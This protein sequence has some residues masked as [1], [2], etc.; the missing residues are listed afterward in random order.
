ML[1][2]QALQATEGSRAI[3]LCLEIEDP[4]L[5]EEC[6]SGSVRLHPGQA[7]ACEGIEDPRWAGECWFSVAESQAPD[8]WAALDS[9]AKAGPYLQE[10]LYHLWTTELSQLLEQAPSIEE[11]MAPGIEIVEFWSGAEHLVMDPRTQLWNDFWFFAI[12]H[13][14]PADST[15]C[16]ELNPSIQLRCTDGLKAGVQRTLVDVLEDPSTPDGEADRACRSGSFSPSLLET[17][18]LNEA[19]LIDAASEATGL[20]CALAQGEPI[21]RWNPVFREL[22]P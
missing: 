12:R 5:S 16:E 20:A 21:P 22:S 3:E 2:S 9:C 11:A 4:G 13:H 18:T 10:C 6:I 1:Y 15:W 7:A 17:I 14:G 8:R 19:D